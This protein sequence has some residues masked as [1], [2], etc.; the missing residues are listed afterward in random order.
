MSKEQLGILQLLASDGIVERRKAIL[1][2]EVHI[3]GQFDGTFEEGQSKGGA[4]IGSEVI[5]ASWGSVGGRVGQSS[6][7]M[8]GIAH[9]WIGDVGVSTCIEEECDDGDVAEVTSGE[10]RSQS[11]GIRL[12]DRG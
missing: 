9:A 1:V 2:G 10:K 4:R 11:V 3:R 8:K 5:G 7:K 6:Q 12:V